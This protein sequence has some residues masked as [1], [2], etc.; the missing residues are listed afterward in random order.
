MLIERDRIETWPE[1]GISFEPVK[2]DIHLPSKILD[3]KKLQM[4]G[5][6]ST[7]SILTAGCT[8]EQNQHFQFGLGG[9]AANSL[10]TFANFVV[11]SE[12]K[13]NFLKK[14]G[15][16]A[17]VIGCLGSIHPGIAGAGCAFLSL[18]LA[19]GILRKFD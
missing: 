7:L 17:L 3:S 1:M 18:S 5:L 16:S 10:L 11:W 9:F 13:S 6:A 2:L 15:I 12:D 4:I 8:P 19:R 14:A